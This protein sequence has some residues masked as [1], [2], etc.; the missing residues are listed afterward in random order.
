METDVITQAYEDNTQAM[1]DGTMAAP[2]S[3]DE[4]LLPVPPGEGVTE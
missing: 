2:I 1:D 3:N 4:V